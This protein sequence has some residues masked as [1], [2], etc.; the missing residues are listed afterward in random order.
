MKRVFAITLVILTAVLIWVFGKMLPDFYLD[1]G[2]KA[3]EQHDYVNAYKDLSLAVKLSPRNRE[4]RY[5]YVK[6]LIMLKPTLQ[7]Q[8][9]LYEISQMHVPDSADLV[10]DIQISKW[11]SQILSQVG[12]NYIEKAPFNNE[13]LRW[14][15]GKFPLNVFIQNNSTTAPPYFQQQIQK[16]FMQWQASTGKFI[17]FKF[18]DN[19]KYANIFVSINPSTDMKKCTEA[20]CKYTVAYTTPTIRGNLLKKMDIFFY[21]S[22]NLGQ[23]FSAKEIYNT[24]LHEIGHALGIMGHSENKNN[25][26]FME[27]NPNEKDNKFDL[28]RSDFQAISPADLNTLTLLYELVPDITNTPADKF[29]TSRQFFAPIVMGD[30]DTINSQKILEAKNYIKAAPNLPNGYIDIASAYS[31]TKQYSSAIENLNRALEVSSND[32][33][34]FIIYYN[35]AVTYI[36]I[37]DWQNALKYAQSA[38]L[39]KPSSDIDGLLAMINYNLGNKKAAKQIYKEALSKSPDNTIDAV[40]LAIIYLKEFDFSDAGKTLNSLIQANPDAKND[41]RVKVYSWLMLFK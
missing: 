2:K 16:A 7:I 5:Y 24:A 33:E 23:P 1:L 18:I 37:K 39:I 28:L 20:D 31:E 8:K 38:K 30:D 22:N 27:E 25:L 19:E 4:I 40:N 9:A 17:R 14:D 15:A 41:P 10:S 12:E 32:N 29:D 21:D 34:R 11:K 3:Y 35:F 6:T 13:I 36:Q 26:M